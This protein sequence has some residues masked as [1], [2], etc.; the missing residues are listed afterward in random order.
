MN[1]SKEF[2][3]KAGGSDVYLFTISNSDN[4][5]VKISNY[6]GI[7]TSIIV[8]DCNNKLTDV[9]LGFD[10]LENY[11][12][13]H[14][15]LGATIGRFGN[16]IGNG[17]FILDGVEYKLA[18]NDGKNHL[19]GGEKGFDKV[20]WDVELHDRQNLNLVYYSEDMEEGYPGNLK[21]SVK[22]RLTD[23]N[24]LVITYNA[25]VDRKTIINLTNHSYFNLNGE[26]SDG[27]IL[28]HKL[29]VKSSQYT[30]TD[31]E[32]IPTGVISSVAGTPLD[33][34]EFTEIGLR[35]NDSFEQLLFAGGYDHNY[36]IDDADG[37]LK[38]AAELQGD[39]SG[40]K[41]EVLT[42]E[43]AIQV[44]SGNYLDGSVQGKSGKVYAKRTGLCL[45]TQHYP[46]SP[47]HPDFP[48]TTL[49]PGE[50]FISKTIY[51]FSS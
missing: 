23:S 20:V 1:A 32:S 17:K 4:M 41:M 5:T 2:W 50:K 12:K 35:I 42:T 21:V 9:A 29:K 22:F 16:R 19:H 34:S 44:Y 39:K 27:D 49:T 47:N 48:T 40:I 30:E 15:Y 10:K 31:K 25:E 3:G 43:P 51:K 6:G 36:I 14:P 33:F 38:F 18:L 8:P 45:E 46:D 13:P 28:S 26:G 37:N 7:I 11:L 24:E